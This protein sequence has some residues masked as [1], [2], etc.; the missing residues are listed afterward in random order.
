MGEAARIGAGRRSTASMVGDV[1]LGSLIEAVGGANDG[2][3]VLDDAILP[4]EGAGDGPRD[5]VLTLP[6]TAV[7]NDDDDER[8][9]PAGR[10][11]EEVDDT[12]VFLGTTTSIDGGGLETVE[13]GGGAA[14][15]TDVSVGVEDR[16]NS[17]SVDVPRKVTSGGRTLESLRTCSDLSLA[18]TGKPS[19]SSFSS[20]SSSSCL[21][22]PSC[23]FWFLLVWD[24]R[25]RAVWAS[26]TSGRDGG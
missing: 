5:G 26:T 22:S 16:C 20:S 12:E 4:S 3:G 9:S 21:S 10:G 23:S 18:T 25:R 8:R 14:G 7:G 11:P 1:D 6:S 19:S 2:D 17:L 24:S 13:G 15:S